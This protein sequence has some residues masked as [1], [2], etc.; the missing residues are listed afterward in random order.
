[1]L[2]LSALVA[3][4]ALSPKQTS[5]REV[6]FAAIVQPGGSG[7]EAGLPVYGTI[8]AAL[9]A[10]PDNARKPH[11]ILVRA[12]VYFE[13][14]TIT[15][16]HI[17]LV[18]TGRDQTRIHYDAYAGQEYAPGKTWGTGGSSTVIVRATDVQFHN[19]TIENS[20]DFVTND[21]R[22]P[23]AS[24]RIG[25]TQAVALNLDRGSDRILGRNVTLL[26]YQDT[27]YVHSGR[28]WFD[29]SLIAGN[30]DFIFGAGNALFTQSDIVT[31]T[32][33][34]A[35]R[36]HG[37]LTAPSTDIGQPYGLTFIDC[38]LIREPGVPDNSTALGRP[39]HPTTSFPDGRYADPNAIGKAVFIRSYVDNHIL[40]EGWTPMGGTAPDGS[41]KQFMPDTDARF[42]EY[43]SFGPGAS[44]EHPLRTQLT[45]E[46]AA[47]YTRERILG[48]WQ[49]E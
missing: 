42:R 13:K 15:K 27:L 35:Q 16:P 41:R 38:R 39:W 30:V 1:M 28:S 11:R 29:Q 3:A 2:V 33:G 9:A 14:L 46:Q 34:S 10:A 49:P 40:A 25:G 7:T 31:R 48:D 17:H 8:E 6:P 44:T 19:L 12:G 43:G 45:D 24:E 21:A 26:G 32:R 22:D 5:T 37:Y 47:T 23:D 4:C 36:V 18:G 20:F